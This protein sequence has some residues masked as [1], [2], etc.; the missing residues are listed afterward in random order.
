MPDTQTSR[1]GVRDP[2]L[3]RVL[4][5]AAVVVCALLAWAWREVALLAFA[6]VLIAVGLH[7]IADPLVRRTPLSRAAAL[8][9]AGLILLGALSGLAWLFGAQLDGQVQSMSQQFPEAWQRLR[10]TLRTSELGAALVSEAE[11]WATEGLRLDGAIAQIGGYTMSAANALTTALLVVF[12]AIFF[13][14]SPQ[15]YVKGTLHLFPYRIRGAV[16]SA[17]SDIA[18]A[19][20]KWLLG[21][22]ISMLVITLMMG[23]ALAMLGVPGFLALALLAG[24][25]QF[26]PVVGP[27]LAAIPG[28]LLALTVGPE[29]A[30]WTALAYFVASQLEANLVYPLVQKQAVS[31][32]PALTLFAIIAMGLLFGPLGILVATP[33]LVVVSILIARFYVRGAL[34]DEV[35]V[36]GA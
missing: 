31:L 23:A 9:L 2:F 36:P 10:E 11:S 7:G 19:L 4:I 14:V 8:G 20:K 12:A 34:G 22:L 6:A 35:R 5:V 21:S 18:R 28:V 1:S 24:I 29:T 13:A 16:E 32:P 26:V 17:M 33:A 3:Q 25:A 27:I 30:A 15:V